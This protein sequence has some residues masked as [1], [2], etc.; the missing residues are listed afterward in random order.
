MLL[1]VRIIPFE[2]MIN[3]VTH[4]LEYLNLIEAKFHNIIYLVIKWSKIH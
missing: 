4:N 1:E 2:S 3:N